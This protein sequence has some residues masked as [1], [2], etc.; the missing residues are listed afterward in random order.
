MGRKKSCHSN[1][2]QII[3]RETCLNNDIQK[4]SRLSNFHI[5]LRLLL[6]RD[7]D[8]EK[9]RVTYQASK[10][11]ISITYL[12]IIFYITVFAI[13]VSLVTTPLIFI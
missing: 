8:L 7:F 9:F 13:F 10:L 11:Y 1:E 2:E 5:L 12:I 3:S 4:V 6:S